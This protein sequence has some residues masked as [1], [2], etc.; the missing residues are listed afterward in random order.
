MIWRDVFMQVVVVRPSDY[1]AARAVTI[2][3]IEDGKSGL[4][5]CPRRAST[6]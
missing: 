5:I 4:A 1:A 6:A 3:A 2:L